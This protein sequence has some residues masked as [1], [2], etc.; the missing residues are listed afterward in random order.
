MVKLQKSW[1]RGGRRVVYCARTQGSPAIYYRG[2][3]AARRVTVWAWPMAILMPHSQG[4][5][6]SLRRRA[7]TRLSPPAG[8]R[9]VSDPGLKRTDTPH[10][11]PDLEPT[12]PSRSWELQACATRLGER[13]RKWGAF[14][15]L[16]FRPK[17]RGGTN[18]TR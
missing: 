13:T 14:I 5:A 3:S 18:Y 6:K 9:A 4:D 10:S 8:L 15:E 2:D 7:H 11:R 1:L 17:W 12:L 16:G